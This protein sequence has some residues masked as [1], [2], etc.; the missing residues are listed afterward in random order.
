MVGPLWNQVTQLLRWKCVSEERRIYDTENENLKKKEEEDE[1]GIRFVVVFGTQKW[2]Y[3]CLCFWFVNIRYEFRKIR[4]Y[5]N[6][7]VRV[8]LHSF[9]GNIFIGWLTNT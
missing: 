3:G 6:V 9:V 7:S 2:N 1:E 4:G 8:L 5:G